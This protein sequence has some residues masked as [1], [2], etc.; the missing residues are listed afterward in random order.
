LP[1]APV[2]CV[3]DRK[4]GHDRRRLQHLAIGLQI[5]SHC[6][7]FATVIEVLEG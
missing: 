7:K 3:L 1:P 2:Q 5:Y 4:L 6:C